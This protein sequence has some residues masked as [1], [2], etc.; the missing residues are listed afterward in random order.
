V[1]TATRGSGAPREVSGPQRL[2]LLYLWYRDGVSPRL[3]AADVAFHS[4]RGAAL[5]SP[6]A[7]DWS[8]FPWADA[9]AAATAVGRRGRIPTPLAV[10]TRG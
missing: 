5:A 3:A 4:A 10:K 2:A 8:G 6:R 9:V 7:V 1:S